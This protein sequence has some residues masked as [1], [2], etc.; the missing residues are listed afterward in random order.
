MA[1]CF[2]VP[3]EQSWLKWH[4]F[5]HAFCGKNLTGKGVKGG[6]PFTPFPVEAILKAFL[7]YT[8]AVDKVHTQSLPQKA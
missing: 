7:R 4:H 5:N 3:L 2:Y 6:A 8:Y 1:F